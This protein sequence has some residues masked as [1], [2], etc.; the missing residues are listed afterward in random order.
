MMTGPEKW[1]GINLATG[2]KNVLIGEDLAPTLEASLMEFLSNRLDTFALEQEDI[3]GISADVITH[4]L[5]WIR[6]THLSNKIEENSALR[7]TKSSTK[8]SID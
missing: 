4:K 2:D 7:E 1:A 6:N 3:T 8:K 5:M